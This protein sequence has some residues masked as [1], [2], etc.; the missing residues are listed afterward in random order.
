MG[1]PLAD[2]IRRWHGHPA[3]DLGRHNHSPALECLSLVGPFIAGSG[4]RLRC[5]IGSRKRPLHNRC[6]DGGPV[7]FLRNHPE[8]HCHT[9]FAIS[10]AGAPSSSLVFSPRP[11]ID[12][13]LGG[14]NFG[15]CL[16]CKGGR[17][18]PT[19]TYKRYPGCAIWLFN[20]MSSCAKLNIC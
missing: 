12:S 14:D 19:A 20:R 17:E 4:C 11:P 10:S 16:V 15:Y 8:S 13:S 9:R 5:W 2:S 18:A 6:G 7:R 1:E 3:L